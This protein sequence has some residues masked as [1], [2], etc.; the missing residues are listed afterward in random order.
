MGKSKVL[1]TI[2]NLC[3]YIKSFNNENPMLGVHS[4]TDRNSQKLALCIHVT[5]Y[6]QR[7]NFHQGLKSNDRKD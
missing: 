1:I 3:Q 7:I 5:L 4:K 2:H 6:C